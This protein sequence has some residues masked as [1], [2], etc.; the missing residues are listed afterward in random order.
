MRAR[1]SPCGRCRFPLTRQHHNAGEPKFFHPGA[2]FSL[3][4]TRKSA[5]LLGGDKI[6]GKFLE[7]AQR[8]NRRKSSIVREK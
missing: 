5:A 6:F 1:S 2:K 4:K 8:S 3:A 7:K